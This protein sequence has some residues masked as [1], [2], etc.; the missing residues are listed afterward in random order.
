MSSRPEQ[1]TLLQ[2]FAMTAHNRSFG[3]LCLCLRGT[4]PRAPNWLSIIALANQTLTTPFL[5][6]FVRDC[7]HEIPEDVRIYIEELFERNVVRN[8]RLAAQL[9]EALAALNARGITPVL[10]KGAATLTSPDRNRRG[11]R[12]ISD[13]DLMVFPH[14]ATTALEALSELGYRVHHMAPD[15]AEK[16]YAD[17]ARENDVG[18]I[19]L[20][21]SLPGPAFYYRALGEI[22]NDCRL[23]TAEQGNALLPSPTCQALILVI[24][25]QF[26]DNDYWVGDIDL[27]HLL[28]L[29]DLAASAEGI[30]WSRLA[31]LA[32]GTLGRNALETELLA[33]SALLGGIVPVAMR[34]RLVPRLQYRRRILQIRF[35][36]L[37]PLLMAT[38]LIDLVHY[39][40]EIG[41]QVTKIKAQP[42]NT[43]VAQNGNFTLFTRTCPGTPQFQALTAPP[44]AGEAAQRWS[45]VSRDCRDST[46][47]PRRPVAARSRSS[48][49]AMSLSFSVVVDSSAD[50]LAI[51]RRRSLISKSLRKT[52]CMLQPWTSCWKLNLCAGEGGAV[53]GCPL[54]GRR[55]QHGGACEVKH[56]GAQRARARERRPTAIWYV[57]GDLPVRIRR[58]AFP[59]SVGD[60]HRTSLSMISAA[61]C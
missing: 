23:I 18:M 32:V 24:H 47:K 29:R 60:V 34:R 54:P 21:T 55:G 13:L 58:P 44:L 14:E 33:F 56:D 40:A 36:A 42:R 51:S 50:F 38:A 19:D 8:D 28:D 17:L 6:D 3:D 16:W 31:S 22:R 39:R 9:G 45:V 57:A 26:Q 35:P 20:H 5:I 49:A 30:D 53:E 27:R 59:Q 10:L 46:N 37:R 41:S 52:L 7:A 2:L 43:P 4:L 12:I 61:I 15:K 11:R 1:L 25:D 48:C